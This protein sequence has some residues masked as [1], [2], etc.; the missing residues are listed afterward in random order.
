MPPPARQRN[1]NCNAVVLLALKTPPTSPHSVA[2]AVAGRLGALAALPAQPPCLNLGTV[3]AR[4]LG[5]VLCLEGLRQSR[6]LLSAALVP[7]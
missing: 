7:R 1:C 3:C 6:F 2:V 4:R 5:S